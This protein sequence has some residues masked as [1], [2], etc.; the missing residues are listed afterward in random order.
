MVES[1]NEKYWSGVVEI[2]HYYQ[3]IEYPLFNSSVTSEI[4]SQA[5]CANSQIKTMGDGNFKEM[6]RT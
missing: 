5:L 4:L 3:K 2:K 6:Y 1:E